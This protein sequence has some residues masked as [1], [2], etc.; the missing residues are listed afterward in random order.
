MRKMDE[1]KLLICGQN[2]GCTSGDQCKFY[3]DNIEPIDKK[4]L[5][6][7]A[8]EKYAEEL[9]ESQSIYRHEKSWIVS[10][11]TTFYEQLQQKQSAGVWVKA[12]EKLPEM[13]GYYNGKFNHI[14]VQ[15][16]IAN[17]EVSLLGISGKF[18]PKT[19]LQ[20]LEWLDESKEQKKLSDEEISNL[21]ELDYPTDNWSNSEIRRAW[22][23]GF[24]AALNYKYG[25]KT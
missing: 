25:N 1:E 8:A 19:D 6:N 2:C 10:V 14:A 11:V 24:K 23:R 3:K 13:D 4:K 5:F 9:I 20:Y 21:A 7:K 15:I 17:G 12:S 16:D 18:D 22:Y